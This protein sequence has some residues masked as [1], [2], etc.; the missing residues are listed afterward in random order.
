MDGYL[1]K[2][3]SENKGVNSIDSDNVNKNRTAHA[4]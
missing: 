4:N 1:G 2:N 3:S